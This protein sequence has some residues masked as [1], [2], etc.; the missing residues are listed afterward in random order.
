MLKAMK[1]TVRARF[2][3]H[4]RLSDLDVQLNRVVAVASA[5]VIFLTVAPYILKSPP[6]V[7]DILNLFTVLSSIF[8]LVASLL[9]YSSQNALT[10]EQHHRSALE[11]NEIVRDLELKSADKPEAVDL[12]IDR[13]NLVLQ[14]YSVNH[15]QSDY[16]EVIIERKHDYPWVTP[17][18]ERRL[19][20]SIRWKN[21]VPNGWFVLVC[22]MS[23]F[24]IA[25]AII[26]PNYISRE[27]SEDTRQI[28]EEIRALQSL[29]KE[30]KSMS[31]Q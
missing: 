9:Q 23:V 5:L 2:K 10:A 7:S 1:D 22:A 29:I 14:K 18:I 3:A 6:I 31:P 30:G 11:I 20:K 13:Y 19:K 8:I 16:N 15:E 28:K 12:A 27:P 21:V 17:E 25:F 4:K 24:L 26:A